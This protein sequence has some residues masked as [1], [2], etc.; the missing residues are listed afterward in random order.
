MV[1]PSATVELPEEDL[2]Y[3]HKLELTRLSFERA[4]HERLEIEEPSEF[5]IID[6]NSA[7]YTTIDGNVLA[8][9]KWDL[10]ALYHEVP[11]SDPESSSY[12]WTWAWGL[13]PPN[14]DSRPD[15]VRKVIQASA[16]PKTLTENES[17][18]FPNDIVISYILARIA[19]LLKYR[20]IHIMPGDNGTFTAFGIREVQWSNYDPDA[21]KAQLYYNVQA[22]ART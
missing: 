19:D 22:N 8:T 18:Q 16:I 10:L 11:T 7:E 4:L 21:H 1:K 20:H 12:Q 17:F 2:L 13:I 3:L 9:V 15:V 5:K 14:P 6:D